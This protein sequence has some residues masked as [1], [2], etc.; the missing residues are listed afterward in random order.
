MNV[1]NSGFDVPS[2]D[3]NITESAKENNNY[4]LF[5]PGTDILVVFIIKFLNLIQSLF[6]IV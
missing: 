6:S 5:Q 4:F 3:V 1:E 2:D